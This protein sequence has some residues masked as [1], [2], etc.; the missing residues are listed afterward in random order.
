MK[1]V[2]LNYVWGM[3]VRF[4]ELIDQIILMAFWDIGIGVLLG[5]WSKCSRVCTVFSQYLSIN[6]HN[7]NLRV[8]RLRIRFEFACGILV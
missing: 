5:C 6:A 2:Y 1:I 4:M 8:I 3:F 7:S